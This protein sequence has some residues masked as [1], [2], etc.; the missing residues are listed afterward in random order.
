MARQTKTIEKLVEMKK[1][2]VEA[3]EASHA[4]ASAAANA[5]EQAR[6]R[7][8]R[9]WLSALDQDGDI[10]SVAD[11]VHRDQYV[12]SLRRGVDAAELRFFNAR[13]LENERLAA[14]TE[15][16]VDL[17]RYETW[18]EKDAAVRADERRRLER[19]AEDEVTSRK[20]RIG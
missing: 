15:A 17:K 20:R 12:R 19:I 4:A 11:L 2:S 8:D 7:A 16:R 6:I 14:M 3:Q 18:L 1:R 13:A 9:A 10:S 5:A